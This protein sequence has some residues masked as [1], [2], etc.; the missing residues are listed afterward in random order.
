[1]TQRETL[2]QNRAAIAA[3]LPPK[4]QQAA[5]NLKWSGR[6]GFWTQL[7]L[8]IISAVTVLFASISLGDPD[9]NRTQGTEFGIL[10]AVLGL[11]VL[12][13]AMYFAWRYMAISRLLRSPNPAQRPSK[14]DTLQVIRLGLT[15]NM[16]GMLIAIIGA[17]TIA[18][19]VLAKSLSLPPNA[20]SA[21]DLSRFV[22]SLDL[23]IVQAN[24]NSIAAHFAG[25]VSSLVL[26]DRITR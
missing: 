14:P 18:G 16:V 26:L 23:L 6:I 19:I 17:E 10:C 13:V 3:P 25:I 15:V 4:L 12:V 22:N 5:D 8:G 2:K 20:I 9:R 7:V 11:I 1:M 21:E 24:T